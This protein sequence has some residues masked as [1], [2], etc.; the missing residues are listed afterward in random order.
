ML[1]F[2]LV[3][4]IS[5]VAALDISGLREF[6][7]STYIRRES[8]EWNPKSR[9]FAAKGYTPSWDVYNLHHVCVQK[10]AEGIYVGTRD[11]II[12]W[13]DE[14]ED[15]TAKHY[16]VSDTEW[17]S[18]KHI[19]DLKKNLMETYTAKRFDLSTHSI[20]KI[21]FLEK[22]SFFFNCEQHSRDIMAHGDWVVKHGVLYELSNF[23]NK[24]KGKSTFKYPWPS[25]FK[26]IFMNRCS[27]PEKADWNFGNP[28]MEIVKRRTDAYGVTKNGFTSYLRTAPS[29][30]STDL[31]CFED[32][33]LSGR[34]SATL[35][36]QDNLMEFRRDTAVILGEPNE[37]LSDPEEEVNITPGYVQQM[38]C[39]S[40]D[41]RIKILQL[42][43]EP[44]NRRFTNM[45]DVVSV[46]Q[47]FSTIPVEVLVI[48]RKMSLPEIIDYFNSF[49]ILVS[50]VGSHL[51]HG[52][53]TAFPF[54]KALI[55]ISPFLKDPYFHR[56]FSRHFLFADYVVSTGHLSRGLENVCAFQKY[57]HFEKANCS[58]NH[59]SYF[60]RFRQERIICPHIF[61]SALD[62]DIE[63]IY[64]ESTNYVPRSNINNSF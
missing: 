26:N 42:D 10:G 8:A 44:F 21:I 1:Q 47:R 23:F 62:C 18:L 2:I 24:N 13:K 6:F 29:I 52:L 54:T 53:F 28:I 40:R 48:S 31:V 63:V 38:Y 57:H 15:K 60:K 30:D 45:D 41:F 22:G 4:A 55:E 34:L 49:D 20:K 27:D 43:G 39:K 5:T 16:L 46:L 14:T 33:Y 32:I 51:I 37:V 12:N 56:V 59:H 58:L 17:N 25:P 11:K 61:S 64:F 50:P 3:L 35:Q 19:S 9:D 36:G 7:N